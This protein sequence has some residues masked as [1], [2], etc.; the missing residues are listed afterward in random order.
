MHLYLHTFIFCRKVYVY[1]YMYIYIYMYVQIPV[2]LYT[3]RLISL[4]KGPRQMAEMKLGFGI[5]I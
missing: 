1:T 4:H 2:H 5:Y 3:Q